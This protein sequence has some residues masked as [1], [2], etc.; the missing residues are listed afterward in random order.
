MTRDMEDKLISCKS[1]SEFAT[2]FMGL[3]MRDKLSVFTEEV[4]V[5]KG[6]NFYRIRKIN[7]NKDPYDPV[8][9]EP[10]PE[11]LSNKG[12]FNEKGKSVLYIAS[13]PFALER[14]VRLHEGEEYYLA[15]Y[16]C[17]N[18]FTVG[19]FLGVNSQVNTLV[20]KITMAVHGCEDMTESENKLIDEYYEEA[21]YKGLVDL[22]VDMLAS[23]YIYKMLPELYDITN[24]LAKLIFMKNKYGIRYSSVFVPIEL[25]G[26]PQIVTLDG[27]ETGNFVLTRKGYEN[28]SLISVEK[29]VCDKPMELDIMIKTFAE[30]AEKRRSGIIL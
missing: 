4:P 8:E 26:A 30:A 19:S 6:K 18:S 10:V 15:K 1:L 20:H 27:T 28:I 13:D 17:N 16:V 25:S 3:S 9:W 29:K 11:E 12:R 23:W 21:N 7:G 5:S 2:M 14:E 22:S 24:K